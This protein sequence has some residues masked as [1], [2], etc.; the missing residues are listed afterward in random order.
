[1]EENLNSDYIELQIHN[2]IEERTSWLIDIMG[3]KSSEYEY[4]Y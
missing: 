3:R 4:F 1:M 2:T